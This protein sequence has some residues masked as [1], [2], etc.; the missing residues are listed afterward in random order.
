[1]ELPLHYAPSALSIHQPI[2]DFSLHPGR[3]SQTGV[4][5]TKLTHLLHCSRGAN[6]GQRGQQLHM[7]TDV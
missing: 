3:I 4:S 6:S 1:M 2:P 5:R 7:K